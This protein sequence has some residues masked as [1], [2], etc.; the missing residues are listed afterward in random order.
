MARLPLLRRHRL[1]GPQGQS[2]VAAAAYRAGETLHDERTGEIKDY[3]RRA[4]SVLYTQ[5]L[6]PENA[7]AWMRDRQRLWNGVEHREDRSTKRGTAQLARNIELS[8]PHELT[9]EQHVELVCEFVKD[10]FVDRGMVADIA[11]HAPPYRGDGTNHHAH[12]LLTMRDIEDDGFGNKNRAWN[13]DELLEHWR[14]RWAD[15]QNRALEK[16]GF[17]ARVDHRSLEDQGI[18]REPTT[19]LGPNAQALEDQGIPTDR[20]DENRRRKGANDN[21]EQL[22]AELADINRRIAAVERIQR[23]V[24]AVEKGYQ[25]FE[26]SARPE[27]EPPSPELETRRPQSYAGG[28]EA[29]PMPDSGSPVDKGGVAVD[30]KEQE[31]Q[32]QARKQEEDRQEHARKLEEDRQEQARKEQDRLQQASI[33][34]D[35]RLQELGDQ[36]RERQRQLAEEF[37]KEQE[38]IAAQKKEQ[39][40]FDTRK[41]DPDRIDTHLRQLEETTEGHRQTFIDRDEKKYLEGDIRDPGARYAKALAQNYTLSNPYESLAK[42]AMAEHA[43]FRADQE[44]L[45]SS[46]AKAT[47]PKEREMLQTRKLIEG[48]DYLMITGE[49]IAKMSEILSGELVNGR[50]VSKESIRMREL[51]NGK[52]KFNEKDE[53]IGFEDGYKQKAQKLRQHYRDLQAERREK[54]PERQ[55]TAPQPEPTAPHPGGRPA[56]PLDA[57]IKQ[58]DEAAKAKERESEKKHRAPKA[59]GARARTPAKARPGTIGRPGVAGQPGRTKPTPRKYQSLKPRLLSLFRQVGW[60]LTASNLPSKLRTLWRLIARELTES[61]FHHSK[62]P[63]KAKAPRP[64]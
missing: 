44:T 20:G 18:D 27:P 13:Q 6:T 46:I 21:R 33:A 2:A 57:L 36:F 60:L 52:D 11:I 31:R 51:I 26:Q 47:D 28:P 45:A 37:R 50:L 15:Y 16:Y 25:R 24:A 42:A 7:P 40:R 19:H 39:E 5:I 62:R 34:E 17:E 9:H 29:A 30:D 35:K 12:V 22:K 54:E 8:L 48:Y 63:R 55:R 56:D 53:K 59:A 38:R 64:F 58:Q 10:E 23:I 4:W 3:A 14:E 61:K 32:D 49:R 41:P 1:A 43:S